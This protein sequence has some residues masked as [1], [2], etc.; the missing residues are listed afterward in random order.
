MLVLYRSLEQT[1][2]H[3]Y[4]W[5]FSQVHCSKFYRPA[6]PIPT[7]AMFFSFL[8]IMTTKSWKRVTKGTFL[9][10]YIEIGPV[11]SDKK[12]F[13]VFYIAIKP[14]PLTA[15]FF[16]FFLRN[17]DSLKKLGRVSPK[18]NSCQVKLKSVH[19]FLTR[20]F[21]KFSIYLGKINPTP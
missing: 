3:T 1:D 16:F 15:I 5:S 21:S 19:W 18:E 17:H 11:V 9:P 7:A 20:R 14:Y 13:K 6:P 10:N 2:L 4:C 12:I 8:R